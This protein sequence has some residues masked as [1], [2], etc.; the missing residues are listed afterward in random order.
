MR[1]SVTNR[2]FLASNATLTQPYPRAD[3]VLRPRLIDRVRE[4]VAGPLTLLSAPAGFGKSTALADAL[5]ARAGDVAWLSLDAAD[6]DPL[7]FL[8]YLLGFRE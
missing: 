3:R 8:R 6:S 7:R 5:Q 1:L 4:G 2:S